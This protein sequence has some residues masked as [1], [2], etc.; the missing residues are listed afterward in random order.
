LSGGQKSGNHIFWAMNKNQ[1]ITYFKLWT[2]AENHINCRK[3]KTLTIK[4]NEKE[5]RQQHERF[6]TR[7]QTTWT[8][9][10][11]TDNNLNITRELT[12]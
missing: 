6:N 2:K 9:E 1:E 11:K 3:N 8:S 7:Q 10:R 4:H 5:A 12:T